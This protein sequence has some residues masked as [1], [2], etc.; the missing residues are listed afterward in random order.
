MMSLG[1]VVVRVTTPDD[2]L[3]VEPKLAVPSIVSAACAGE[4]KKIDRTRNATGMRRTLFRS[5]LILR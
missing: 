2:T 3:A 5:G 1:L 4:T